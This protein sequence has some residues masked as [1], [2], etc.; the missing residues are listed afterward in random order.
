MQ[1]DKVHEH[2][3]KLVPQALLDGGASPSILDGDGQSPWA[4][5]E[6]KGDESMMKILS[7]Y[8]GGPS[9]VWSLQVEPSA[10]ETGQEIALVA[11]WGSA[12]LK[13]FMSAECD[14]VMSV[15]CTNLAGETRFRCR[16]PKDVL[17]E[18]VFARIKRDT[19]EVVTLI[20]QTIT[21]LA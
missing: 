8:R 21:S 17:V 20:L 5:A 11:P 14:E 6:A 12:V 4:W 16:F 1:T 7:D 10:N 19:G 3:L 15:F 2:R 13:A 18:D 9:A